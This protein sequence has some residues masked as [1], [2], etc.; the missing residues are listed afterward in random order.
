M[1]TA[2]MKIQTMA[3]FLMAAALVSACGKGKDDNSAQSAASADASASGA[4]ASAVGGALSGSMAG[5]TQAFNEIDRDPARGLWALLLRAARPEI[6][7]ASSLCPTFLTSG[8]GCST[9]GANMWLSY[10]GCTFTGIATWTGVQELSM[11][12]G[13]ASCGTFPN[14][15][16]NATLY[17]QF[18][19]ASGSSTPSSLNLTADNW[20][21]AIDD[22]SSD[23]ANF[24]GQTISTVHNGGYGSA[25]HFA[26]NGTRDSVTIKHRAS[27]T[28]VFDHS[29]AGSLTISEASGASSRTLSG[30]VTVY[31]NRLRV[32]GTSTFS[33]VIHQNVCCLPTSGTITTSFAAGSNVSP[34]TLGNLLVGKSESLTFTGCGTATYTDVNGNQS[35]VTLHRCF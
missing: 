6:A 15:G 17:R 18:V 11:S 26:A 28:G 25:V 3:I 20:S 1:G 31:H 7:Q 32:V 10:S 4:A 13:S 30:S 34:T 29:V 19:S 9:S 24:D 8:A 23:L 27:V 35:S 12:S 33:S 2:K 14:P 5:G 21:A 16:A 22:S